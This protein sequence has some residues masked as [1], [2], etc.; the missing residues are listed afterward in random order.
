MGPAGIGQAGKSTPA[1][2]PRFRPRLQTPEQAGPPPSLARRPAPGRISPTNSPRCCTTCACPAT[3][4][5]P[6]TNPAT[7][8]VN[9]P[10]RPTVAAVRRQDPD[11]AACRGPGNVAGRARGDRRRSRSTRPA[12]PG[13]SPASAA[14]CGRPTT[15]APTGATDRRHA[16]AGHPVPRH[17]RFGQQRHLRR[18]RRELLQ[19]RHHERQ[20][21]LQVHRPGRNLDAAGQHHRRRPL[22]QRVAHHRSPAAPTPCSSRPPSAG[23][24]RASPTSRTSS[25]PPTAAPTGPRC[26]PDTGSGSAHHPARSPTPPTSTS[27]T[28]RSTRRHPEVHRRRPD[29]GLHQH[30]H[31]RLRRPLRAGH[32]AGQHRLPLRLGR[33]LLRQPSCGSPGTAAPT[34]TRPSRSGTE[35][36]WLGAQGWY[37]NTIVCHPTDPDDRL[38]G[39][40]RSSTA[41]SSTRWVRPPAT[42]FPWPATGSPTPTTTSWRSCSPPAA[43]GTCWA[44]T[45]AASPAPPAG[46]SNFTMP[47]DG[48]VTTQF[49]G[50]DKRPG[51]QRLRGRHAGQRHLAVPRPTRTSSRPWDQRDRRR[52]LRDLLALRRPPEDHRRLPVQRPA[53]LARRRRRA[54]VRPPAA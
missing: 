40:T 50:V 27:S 2:H 53:A 22:Q 18:H 10:R 38:R 1:R 21:D 45:T 19:H 36:N 9:W 54:G 35:P 37:D 34:G 14:A 29:L 24:R 30:R 31:H 25:A 5:L 46:V 20:R 41:S 33:G 28:P 52:R 6:N 23:T 11:L 12:A 43:A 32:L 17:G 7:D 49:Y 39:R 13:S 42:P 4:P 3:A 48:M 44:P 26:L 15:A 8:S 16:H 47:T 51:R